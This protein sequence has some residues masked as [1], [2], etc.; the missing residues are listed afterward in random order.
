MKLSENAEKSYK[1]YTL[2][3][4]HSHICFNIN[5]EFVET[6]QQKTAKSNAAKDVMQI[7]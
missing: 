5:R 2:Q 7:G 3:P 4:I 6:R 1:S